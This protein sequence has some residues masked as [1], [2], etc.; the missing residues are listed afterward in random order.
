LLLH[1]GQEVSLNNLSKDER[2]GAQIVLNALEEPLKRIAENSGYQGNVIAEKVRTL[3][4]H[5]GFDALTGEL[6]NMVESGIIDPAKVTRAALQNAVSIASLVLT[7]QTL[8]AEAK[9]ENPEQWQQTTR[10]F[11]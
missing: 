6:V 9:E 8:I 10:V 4:K 5:I 1:I 3:D 11:Q 2:V 7:T